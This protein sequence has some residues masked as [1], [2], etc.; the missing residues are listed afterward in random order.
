MITLEKLYDLELE[1]KSEFLT[2]LKNDPKTLN[3]AFLTKI[4]IW[5]PEA[6][7]LFSARHSG[8]FTCSINWSDE[9]PQLNRNDNIF[10]LLGCYQSQDPEWQEEGR[11]IMY[12]NAIWE[13]AEEMVKS[14]E[15][16]V[17]VEEL[18]NKLTRI[19]LIHELSHWVFHW[20]PCN[21]VSGKIQRNKIYKSFNTDLHEF[22]AQYFTWIAISKVER[23]QQEG[24]LSVFED[25]CKNQP[26]LYSLYEK[27]KEIDFEQVLFAI[28]NLRNVGKNYDWLIEDAKSNKA[29]MDAKKLELL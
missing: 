16:N 27:A 29:K 8:Y 15:N 17:P 12:P 14:P 13:F 9:K 7:P 10:D 22:V 3:S 18:F 20:M 24:L 23:F 1:T 21:S 25:L 19:I 6:F 28:S 2:F 4:R 5:L 26:Q 11:I